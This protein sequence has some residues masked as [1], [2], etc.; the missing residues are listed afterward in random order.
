MAAVSETSSALRPLYI[1][2]VAATI[3]FLAYAVWDYT[4]PLAK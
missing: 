2:L 1:S 3:I 4:L